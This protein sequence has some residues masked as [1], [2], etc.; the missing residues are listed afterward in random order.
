MSEM[1][2]SN[3]RPDA[4]R[5]SWIPGAF[6]RFTPHGHP[7]TDECHTTNSGCSHGY[8]QIGYACFRADRAT[9]RTISIGATDCRSDSEGETRTIRPP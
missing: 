5:E 6:S 8:W 9:Q 4:P 7:P 1:H 3:P 2:A